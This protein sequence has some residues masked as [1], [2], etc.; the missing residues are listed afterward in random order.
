LKKDDST[1]SS[2]LGVIY[3]QNNDNNTAEKYFN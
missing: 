2:S 3:M 1:A